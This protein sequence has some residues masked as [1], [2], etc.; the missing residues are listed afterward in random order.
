MA[1][2]VDEKYTVKVVDA[3]LTESKEKG[4]PGLYVE[5][6]CA[7]GK[8]YHTFYITQATVFRLKENLEKCFGITAAQLADNAFLDRIGNFLRDQEC[9]ITTIGKEYNDKI[10]P[11][12]QWMNP[13][14]NKPKKVEGSGVKRVAE[15]FGGGP[16]SS[17]AYKGDDFEMPPPTT[18][19]DDDTPF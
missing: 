8:I 14:R 11:E 5:F 9:Q 7:E 17:P 16:M 13:V 2:K 3:Y 19:A 4:T 15:L 18:W 10:I 1:L 12:V 6:Q